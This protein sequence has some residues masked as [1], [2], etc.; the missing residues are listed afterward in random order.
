MNG[1]L[2]ISWS[3]LW[4]RWMLYAGVSVHLEWRMQVLGCYFI[5]DWRGTG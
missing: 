1:L 2:W 5:P 3:G 4:L